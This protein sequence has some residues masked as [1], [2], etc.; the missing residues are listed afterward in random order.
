M[1]FQE[2]VTL[3]SPVSG[4][5]HA[6]PTHLDGLELVDIEAIVIEGCR[7]G[8]DVNIR[9]TDGGELLA[10]LRGSR[11][12]FCISRNARAYRISNSDG[13]VAAEADNIG[14]ILAA[15]P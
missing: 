4:D 7:L 13:H 3:L 8:L 2:V 14:E 5:R 15:L 12:T 6:T 10:L 1:T 11:T 9:A